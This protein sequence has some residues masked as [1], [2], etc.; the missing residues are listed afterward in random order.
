MT[1]PDGAV[2]STVAVRDEIVNLGGS[3]TLVTSIWDVTS[4]TPYIFDTFPDIC[5]KNIDYILY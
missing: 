4:V 3:S 2:S 5:G 1:V